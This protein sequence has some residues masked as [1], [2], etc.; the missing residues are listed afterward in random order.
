MRLSDIIHMAGDYVV[1]GIGAVVAAALILGLGYGLVYRKAMKGTRTFSKVQLLFAALFLIYLV[2]LAGATFLGRAGIGYGGLSG[3]GLFRSYLDA[4]QHFSTVEWRNLILNICLF[5]PMGILLPLVFPGMRRFFKVY[6][7]GFLVTVFIELFQKISGRGVME[8][9]DILNNTVG[10]MIGYGLVMLVLLGIA[11]AGKKNNQQKPMKTIRNGI[12]L[13]LP[14]IFTVA[15]FILIFTIYNQKELGN[16][17]YRQ[18]LPVNME[19]VTVESKITFSD[20]TQ[21]AWIYRTKT[22]SR[23]DADQMAESF[24]TALNTE[25]DET[26]TDPYDESVLYWSADGKYS[27]WVHYAGMTWEFTDFDL[28]ETESATELSGE[29]AAQLLGSYSVNLPAG[30]ALE[31]DG[32]D[33]YRI[34]ARPS[35]DGSSTFGGEFRCELT[36]DGKV[37]SINNHLITYTPYRSCGIVSEQQAYEKLQQGY[38]N[39]PGEVL[40]ITVLGVD[41]DLAM[42]SKGYAQPVYRFEVR[43]D[44]SGE[45]EIVIPALERQTGEDAIE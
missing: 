13:Q 19:G 17:A 23:Q 40:R 41:M 43:M 12:C 42:D 11:S 3:Q 30:A 39:D 32:T 10:T 5:I 2:V 38:F 35:A 22:G 18:I 15:A 33:S 31:A 36:K 6:L 34:K 9:D 29:E 21:N 26:R 27:F 44:G 7:T 16:L 14:L 45:Q 8:A 25:I 20:Q 37:K 1:L 28:L 24:F 4:W